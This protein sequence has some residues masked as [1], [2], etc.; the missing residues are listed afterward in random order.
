M[1]HETAVEEKFSI[2]KFAP[3]IL[4]T[5]ALVLVYAYFVMP[6]SMWNAQ[7]GELASHWYWFDLEVLGI[8]LA[9]Q[10]FNCFAEYFFHR[11]VLHAPVIP[12]LNR[13]FRQHH[14]VHHNLT[15]VTAVPRDNPTKWMNKFA[16]VSSWQYP[17]SFF[18][19]YSYLGF[20]VACSPIIVLLQWLVPSWPI[21]IVMV[22]SIGWS[23]VSYELIHAVEHLDEEKFWNGFVFKIAR[24]LG[25]ENA[26]KKVY[27]FHV[28]H[29]AHIKCNEA[30]SG[31]VCGLPVADWLF[32]TLKLSADIPV[33]GKPVTPADLAVPR[34]RFALIRYFD[35]FV[36]PAI[37][38]FRERKRIKVAFA[39]ATPLI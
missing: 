2:V 39:A 9:S 4:G 17:A 8:F 20:V 33:N 12:G 24:R 1:K 16:I 21:A 27:S 3:T 23:L 32:G 19:S 29:H 31:F 36:E 7:W 18:P 15:P 37:A 6:T 34:P 13:L 35:S 26:A 25:M 22:G 38:A 28:F 14:D 30:V 10:K 11:Y 5:F